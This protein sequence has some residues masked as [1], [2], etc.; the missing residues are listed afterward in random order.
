MVDTFTDNIQIFPKVKTKEELAHEVGLALGWDG[1][2]VLGISLKND[3]LR[4]IEHKEGKGVREKINNAFSELGHSI[5]VSELDSYAWYPA[6]YGPAMYLIATHLF[7]WNEED[8]NDLGRVSTHGTMLMK[9]IMHFVSIEKTLEL[10]PKIWHKYYDFG[11]LMPVE[12]SEKDSFVTFRVV[13][14]DVHPISEPYHCGYFCGVVEL[15]TGSL[16]VKAEVVKSVYR[17]AT[18]SEY[19][20]SW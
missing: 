9:V 7:G 2:H 18:Y 3:S 13:G 19:K 8:I 1:G 10:A 4:A 17:G 16:N 20:I 5:Q 12:Y 14:Y 15:V 6:G 11:E